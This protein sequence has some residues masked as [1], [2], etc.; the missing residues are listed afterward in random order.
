MVLKFHNNV[1]DIKL[2]GD[3][4]YTLKYLDL[5]ST[6]IE[7]QISK[8]SY[9]GQ[10]RDKSELVENSE[11]PPFILTFYSY[12]FEHSGIPSENEFV[13]NYLQ[14]FNMNGKG[15]VSIN[16]PPYVFD[17]LPKEMLIGRVLRTYPSLIRDIHFFYLCKESDI[18]ESVKYSLR[19]DYFEGI[20]LIVTLNSCEY[21]ISL[22]VNSKRAN[23]YKKKK[24][25]RHVYNSKVE[26][27]VVLNRD[28]ATN[29]ISDFFLFDRS[30]V[31]LVQ[32]KI[33]DKQINKNSI[34]G[35]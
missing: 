25:R 17:N 34:E 26:I 18:F 14:D 13:I 15:L 4:I 21:H 6:K 30:H 3:Q 5:S 24:E 27:L 28:S 33:L 10:N 16:K 11:L 20:D 23:E 1:I 7:D 8:F 22:F 32:D 31:Q 12:I 35:K 19:I 2:S 9:T 29:K